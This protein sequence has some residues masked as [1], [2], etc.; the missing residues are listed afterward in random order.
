VKRVIILFLVV[1]LLVV[2]GTVLA[3]E[4]ETE[5][6]EEQGTAVEIN[7]EKLKDNDYGVS[8]D[9]GIR[10]GGGP[11]LGV[12]ELDIEDLNEIIGNGFGQFED[13][14]I[15]MGGG[16]LGGMKDGSR[17]GG[18]GLS[19]TVKTTKDDNEAWLAIDY[20][21][22][23]YENGIWAGKKF[24]LAIGALMG[25]GTMTLDLASD[26]P[27]SFEGIVNDIAEAKSNYA[28]LEKEFVLFEPRV[29][30][31]YQFSTFAGLDLG[32]GYLLTHDF[33]ENWTLTGS[34]VT[35]GPLENT[36]GATATA[37]LSFGF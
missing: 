37:R 17:F 19:G 25:G 28:T 34:K 1:S 7:E 30:F 14:M 35:G 9:A 23:L 3:K 22:F 2:S 4:N 26:N 29:N 13:Y 8:G 16:G 20:G 33:G 21:G 12:L 6:K 32:V 27:G 31:H 11:Q 36:Q 15:L 10:G 5:E 18:Y 24:D